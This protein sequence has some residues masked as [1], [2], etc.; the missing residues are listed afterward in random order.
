ML[1]KPSKMLLKPS[2]K[3]TLMPSKPMALSSTADDDEQDEP[4]KGIQASI[5]L[6]TIYEPNKLVLSEPNSRI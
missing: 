2:I 6:V 1:R 4:G 5:C 3:A